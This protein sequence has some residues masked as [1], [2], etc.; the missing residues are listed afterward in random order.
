MG[1][2]VSGVKERREWLV[3]ELEKCDRLIEK[4]EAEANRQPNL[5]AVPP[6]EKPDRKVSAAV[7]WWDLAEAVREQAMARRKITT[8]AHLARP[9]L[10][11]M[12]TLVRDAISH[13]GLVDKID[14]KGRTHSAHDQLLDLFELFLADV[15]FG[16]TDR[17]GLARANAWP[18]RLFLTLAVLDRYRAQQMRTAAAGVA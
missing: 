16:T 2:T 7:Q 11:L 17:E 5:I 8:G 4:L 9:P 15:K 12:N 1:A 10:A 18:I 13:L 14:G 3:R 6:S